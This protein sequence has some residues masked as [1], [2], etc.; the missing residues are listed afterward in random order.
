MK[1]LLQF[2][3]LCLIALAA[4]PKAVAQQ[5]PNIIFIIGDDISWDDIGAYGNAKIKTPN[6]DKLA[7][8]GIKFNNVY[9][10]VRMLVQS[11]PHEHSYRPLSA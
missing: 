1:K 6:L 11:E 2:T 10:P 8:E 3:L 9:L 4:S 7:R 5:T